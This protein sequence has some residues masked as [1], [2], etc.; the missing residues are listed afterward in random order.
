MHSI[1]P[2]RLTPVPSG[3]V[4]AHGP[5]PRIECLDFIERNWTSSILLP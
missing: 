3:W 4:T 1:W 5:A 2:D